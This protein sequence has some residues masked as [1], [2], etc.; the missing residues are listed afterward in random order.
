MT[1][2]I[3]ETYAAAPI[4]EGVATPTGPD[5]RRRIDLFNQPGTHIYVIR[6]RTQ[7]GKGW[8]FGDKFL[9]KK[10]AL[11]GYDKLLATGLYKPDKHP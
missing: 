4:F 11:A 1:S 5:T 6:L 3:D 2:T 8:E 9:C 7:S 10:K